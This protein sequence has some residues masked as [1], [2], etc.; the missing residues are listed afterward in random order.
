MA[1]VAERRQFDLQAGQNEVVWENVCS[2]VETASLHVRRVDGPGEVAVTALRFRDDFSSRQ[3]LLGRYIGKTITVLQA[4]QPGREPE[5]VSGTLV[6]AEGG[7]V[8]VLRSAD[9][10]I[11]VDPIGEVILPKL[12][13]PL[14]EMPRVAVTLEAK[15]AGRYGLELGYLTAGISWSPTYQVAIAADQAKAR[16][17]GWASLSNSTNVSFSEALWR[18]FG[19]AVRKKDLLQPV[20]ERTTVEYSPPGLKRGQSLAS[21]ETLRLPFLAANAVPVETRRVFDPIGAG[22]AAPT[23]PQRLRLVARVR[24]EQASGLGIPLPAGRAFVFEEPAGE[25]GGAP[26]VRAVSELALPAT[27]VGRF[28]DIPLRDIPALSGQRKQTAFRQVADRVQEQDIEITLTNQTKSSVAVVAV[29]HPWGKY[30]VVEKSHEFV[31]EE[32][33]SIEFPVEI[34]AAGSIQV[35]YRIRIRF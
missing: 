13:D 4:G 11:R 30:E 35:S 9:G 3:A 5:R 18:L 31:T 14:G 32:D 22:P 28:L 10:Q 6:S 24:N 1:M 23:P 34:P 20:V 21:G 8:A 19:D 17:A 2:Q 16:I 7:K 12:A 27:L 25:T 15:S 26:G 29:E 33:E